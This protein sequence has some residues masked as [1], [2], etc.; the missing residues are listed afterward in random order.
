MPEPLAITLAGFW[1]IS[2]NFAPV[3]VVIALMVGACWVSQRG[4]DQ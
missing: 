1:Q 4:A 2:Q 3:I